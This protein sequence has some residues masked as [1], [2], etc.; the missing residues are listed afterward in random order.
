M[1]RKLNIALI[2]ALGSAVAASLSAAPAFAVD[3]NPFAAPASGYVVAADQ[4]VQTKCGV[5]KC[6]A[7]MGMTEAEKAA[8]EKAAAEKAKAKAKAKCG[9]GKCGAAMGMSAP[10]KADEGKCGGAKK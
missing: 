6:G 5:G 8:A 4:A 10:A 3:S 1:K 2:L 7:A 9:E